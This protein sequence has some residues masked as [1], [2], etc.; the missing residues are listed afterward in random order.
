MSLVRCGVSA[1]IL[2]SRTVQTFYYGGQLDNPACGGPRPNDDSKIVAVSLS[3]GIPCG[4][5]LHIHRGKKMV[6]VKVVDHCA[7]C[8]RHH[9]DLSKGAFKALGASLD[10]GVLTGL[11][12]RVFPKGT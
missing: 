5:V 11:H 7:G 1:D 8:E 2:A 6:A 4:A 9:L 12:F 10:L 3:S